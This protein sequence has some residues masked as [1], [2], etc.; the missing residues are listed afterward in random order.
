VTE[1]VQQAVTQYMVTT[2]TAIPGSL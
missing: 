1:Q 2:L